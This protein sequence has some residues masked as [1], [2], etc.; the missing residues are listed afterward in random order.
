M[1]VQVKRL[2]VVFAVFVGIMLGLKYFLTP[3]SWGEYGAYRGNALKEIASKDVK[4]VQSETCAM[5][6][7]SIA[8]LKMQGLHKTV[9]CEICH[10]PGYLHVEDDENIDM[11]I[12]N[13]IHFCMRCHTI[14]AASPQ[15]VIKQIDAIEHSE[16]EDCINCHNPHEPWL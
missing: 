13:G 3:D 8:E 2:L 4:F 9:K 5:C 14:N 15:S 11:E 12:P 10:G 7:D 16:N 1:P 6:H